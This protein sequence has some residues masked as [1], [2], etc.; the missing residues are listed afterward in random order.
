MVVQKIRTKRKA[1]R[2]NNRSRRINRTNKKNRTQQRTNRKNRKNRRVKRTKRTLKKGKISKRHLKKD[3]QT[4]GTIDKITSNL[5]FMLAMDKIEF[6]PS[7]NIL[8][9]VSYTHLTLPT[10]PYV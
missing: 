9:T 2:N 5:Q 4:G 7:T 3:L 10:T 6:L 8:E 1:R